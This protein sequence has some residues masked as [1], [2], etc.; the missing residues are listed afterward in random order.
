MV[1]RLIL[2][3]IQ[4]V[5][6]LTTALAYYSVGLDLDFS[7]IRL[8]ILLSEIYWLPFAE[9]FNVSSGGVMAR[10]SRIEPIHLWPLP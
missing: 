3:K 10:R 4:T 7:G 6:L 5:K 8:Y 2:T 1:N 9:I